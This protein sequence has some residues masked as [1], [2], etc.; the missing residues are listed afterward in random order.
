MEHIASLRKTIVR[1][2]GSQGVRSIPMFSG[3]KARFLVAAVHWAKITADDFKRGALPDVV[4]GHL[5]HTKVE[6]SD[7]GKRAACYEDDRS[8]GGIR[9]GVG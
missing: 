5:E 4:A 6:I 1:R 2:S 7:W 8:S 3:Q 9:E